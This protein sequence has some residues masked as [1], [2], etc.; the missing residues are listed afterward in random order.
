MLAKW[1][2]SHESRDYI[3]STSG[4]YSSTSVCSTQFG[5]AAQAEFAHRPDQPQIWRFAN[6]GFRTDWH[7]RKEWASWCYT[8]RVVDLVKVSKG[9]GY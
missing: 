9:A 4:R 3:S 8:T 1:Y 7:A 2:L 5:P 6:Q